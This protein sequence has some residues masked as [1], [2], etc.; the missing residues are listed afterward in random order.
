MIDR[1]RRRRC[2][3]P[4]RRLRPRAPPRPRPR[5]PPRSPSPMG[6]G[7]SQPAD[8]APETKPQAADDLTGSSIVS[9]H[10]DSVASLV[11]PGDNDTDLKAVLSLPQVRP[12][13]PSLRTGA[14]HCSDPSPVTVRS[15]H[16]DREGRPVRQRQVHAARCACSAS[17]LRWPPPS[18][19]TPGGW[20]QR[21]SHRWR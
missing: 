16:Q 21:R 10:G 6:N 12:R 8:P 7:E 15:A 18:D 2:R 3:A 1:R 13:P 9:V 11:R 20:P 5:A 17:S 19:K 14:R 4:G